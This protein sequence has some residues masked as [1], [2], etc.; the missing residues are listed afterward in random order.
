VVDARSDC[1]ECG[2]FFDPEEAFR[3]AKIV[4]SVVIGSKSAPKLYVSGLIEFFSETPRLW[5]KHHL[6]YDLGKQVVEQAHRRLRLQSPGTRR[7]PL[8]R[9]DKSEVTADPKHLRGAQQ[10]RPNDQDTFPEG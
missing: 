8:N 2:Y 9:L 10:V 5:R 1:A 7:R 4:H 3:R 6:G